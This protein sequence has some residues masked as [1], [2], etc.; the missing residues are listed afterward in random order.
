MTGRVLAAALAA[1][2]AIGVPVAL[3]YFSAAKTSPQPISVAPTV[4]ITAA[5]AGVKDS[6]SGTVID[7][8]PAT[9]LDD[10]LFF[11]KGDGLND[12]N[13][14]KFFAPDRFYQWD[15]ASPLPPGQPASDVNFNFAF[16]S[17]R[18]GEVAC[19]YFDVI[20]GGNVI[21]THGSQ[22]PG[23]A[24]SPWCTDFNEKLVSTPLPEVTTTSI[25]NGLRIRVY[26]YQSNRHKM[27]VDLATITGTTT[28][29]NF[30]VYASTA[31]N[32]A[33]ASP[34]TRPEEIRIE[35]SIFLESTNN[36]TN[37]F[38]PARYIE[39]TF[40]PGIVPSSA[41]IDSVTFLH[42][43]QA[44]SG[45]T[46][47]FYLDVIASS[48]SLGTVPSPP[49][50]NGASCATDTKTWV[51]DAIPLP[52]V[53]TAAKANGLVLRLVYRTAAGGGTKSR[54]DYAALRIT[55]Y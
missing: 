44:G 15:F 12:P 32:Q 11:P 48:G 25:A 33:D 53:D 37:V 3:G 45:S 5:A 50:T 40:S 4:T 41:A 54:E 2:G 21:G 26:G 31:T 20:S 52:M 24:T 36:W 23:T 43:Y 14:E 42:R 29:Q 55:Y 39:Y 9:A 35:D 6:S 18:A 27:L 8:S 10:N 19:F 30:T 28:G 16:K 22:T 13:F 1:A 49:G 7:A 38:T 17:D 47:C 46:V 34:E 51:N